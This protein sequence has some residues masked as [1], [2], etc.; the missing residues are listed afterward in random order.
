MTKIHH[1]P[2][3]RAAEQG[4]DALGDAELVALVLGTGSQALSA[5]KVAQALLDDFGGMTGLAHAGVG[6]LAAQRGLGLAKGARIA[7]AVEL[8]K[9]LA[10]AS[11]RHDGES[12]GNAAIVDA[13]ARP[14]MAGL[15]HEELWALAL[16]G[17]DTDRTL[18]VTPLA[19]QSGTTTITVTVR[20]GVATSSDTFVLTVVAGLPTVTTPT[21]D[22]VAATTATLGGN[23]TAD[24]GSAITGRGVVVAIASVNPNPRLL[25]TGVTDFVG[26]GTTGVFTVGT[27][28]L[29]PNTTYAYAA[30][31]TNAV[32]TAY[33]P[34]DTFTTT[35][36][37]DTT[38]PTASITVAASTTLK[39]GDTTGVTIVFSEPVV[40]F[41]LDDVSAANGT[42]GSLA[43]VDN[44]TFTM[45]F[46]PAA[47]VTA[48]T[49]VVTVD[50]TRVADAASNPGVGTSTSNNYAIDTFGTDFVK[51]DYTLVKLDSL[52]RSNIN[53]EVRY[54]YG[55]ELNYEGNQPSSAYTKANLINGTG[56]APEVALNTSVGFYMGQP[57]YGFRY[58]YPDERKWQVGDTASILVGRHNIRFGEDI[59]HNYDLQNNVY[60][61][62]GYI[63]YA[64]AAGSSSVSMIQPRAGR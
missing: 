3:E 30:Y 20:D 44:T 35:A 59:V 41:A 56:F 54:Q 36:P 45:T 11:F 58:A 14:K 24:G 46:T 13:W 27:T 33:S 5:A 57:Y 53:N 64:A 9:R 55:R 49:N 38:P 19:N 4:V 52:L 12:F 61:G 31:A 21:S 34:A 16:D 18:V 2:R 51:L 6:E 40:G 43:T 29:A 8:G 50:L 42:L 17:A 1:G 15:E 7:A 62:N 10:E 22:L 37:A 32:G 23:V 39:I 48:A 25:G 28:T 60:E 47:G 26:T 63:N